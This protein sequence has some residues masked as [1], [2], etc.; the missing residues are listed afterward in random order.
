MRRS[1]RDGTRRS[2]R[3]RLVFV[4]SLAV[5]PVV[6]LSACASSSS[7]TSA[8]P[9][10]EDASLAAE[11]GLPASLI[12]QAQEEGTVSFYTY[13]TP[14]T[15][16]AIAAQFKATFGITVSY[17]RASGNILTD[18]FLADE[19][20]GKDVADVLNIATANSWFNDNQQYFEPLTTSLIPE[21]AKW[22]KSAYLPGP[23]Q[24]KTIAIFMGGLP[25][26]IIYNTNKVQKSEVPTS[27][28][29]LPNSKWN[30]D[31][32]LSDPETSPNYGGWADEMAKMYGMSY[33]TKLK[34][35][36]LSEAQSGPDAAQEAAAGSYELALPVQ[37]SFDSGLSDVAFQ[38]ESG[39][40]L[41]ATTGLSL[42]KNSPHPA[43]GRLLA[44]WLLSKQGVTVQCKSS[45]WA[46]LLDPSGK[47]TG[48]EATPSSF[49]FVP[50]GESTAR[51]NSLYSALGVTS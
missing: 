15:E 26:G 44:D 14:P 21:L 17:Y 3:F 11:Y 28:A 29:D 24:G 36:N 8:A 22:P 31:I 9:T 5:V 38:A 40:Y 48:C 7:A 46:N 42:V 39:P 16:E 49:S 35:L 25:L 41:V 20:S 33:L 51:M 1:N 19:K 37:A 6:A 27:W 45:S 50:Y 34:A 18:R 32:S 4:A 43:A 10:K 13:D 12:K 23:T 47:A 2:R 30:G